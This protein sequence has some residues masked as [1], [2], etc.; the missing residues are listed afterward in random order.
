VVQA[1]DTVA[2]QY[3]QTILGNV[4]ELE[5]CGDAQTVAA[6]LIELSSESEP[7]LERLAGC[8]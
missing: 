7:N 1:T 8:W 4:Q 3:V 5:V 2:E 6:T